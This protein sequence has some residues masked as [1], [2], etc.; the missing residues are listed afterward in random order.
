[1]LKMI[2]KI[3][4]HKS[5]NLVNQQAE[6]FEDQANDQKYKIDTKTFFKYAVKELGLKASEINFEFLK[7]SR[8]FGK[9]TF[10]EYVLYGLYDRKDLNLEE[11]LDFISETLHWGIVEKTCDM[12]W[13]IVTEDKI[14][15]YRLLASMGFPAPETVAIIDDS[16]RQYGNLPKLRTAEELTGFLKS[17]DA[18]PLFAKPNLGIGSFGCFRING[19]NKSSI[20]LEQD[21]ARSASD[22]LADLV[23]SRPFLLQK[24]V[25]NHSKIAAFSPYLATVR[26]T[27]FLQDE[28]VITPLCVLKLPSSSNIADNYWRPGNVL[29]NVDP[30][31][32]IIDR[33][34][35]GKGIEL[36]ILDVHPD[37]QLPLTG[38]QLPLWDQVK[39]LN[40]AVASCFS[41]IKF[42][43]MDI[44]ITDTGPVVIEINTGG[45]FDLPQLASGKGLLTPDVKN[46]L[47]DMEIMK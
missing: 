37:S 15:S 42:Q 23:K 25:L 46:F 8:G 22:L 17:N 11:K 41:P 30:V 10:D 43:S 13:Q 36:E 28:K 47:R 7:L 21:E 39:S 40:K 24:S 34:V 3:F 35:R 27:N 5:H 1:M 44:A 33:A 26:M 18:F 32:G 2:R 9:L 12:S 6:L 29:A 14:L 31:T 19:I 4:G 45:A 20:L 38:M 16:S